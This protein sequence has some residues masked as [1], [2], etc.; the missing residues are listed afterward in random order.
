MDLITGLTSA[1]T[2]GEQLAAERL[3]NGAYGDRNQDEADIGADR[4]N[5]CHPHCGSGQS[6]SKLQ[7]RRRTLKAIKC[8]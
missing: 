5:A 1:R 4:A 8:A 6:P 2:A 3:L 7:T